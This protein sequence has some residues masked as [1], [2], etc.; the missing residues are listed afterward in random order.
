SRVHM[1]L[2]FFFFQAEDG[3]RD[4]HVTGVQT[5][6]LPI[7]PPGGSWTSSRLSRRCGRSSPGEPTRRWSRRA[8]PTGRKATGFAEIGRLTDYGNCSSEIAVRL[9]R[10]AG[11]AGAGRERPLAAASTAGS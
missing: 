2:F 8:E 6:A 7:S 10:S 5:C 1:L 11:P 3:I 9:H 4:F